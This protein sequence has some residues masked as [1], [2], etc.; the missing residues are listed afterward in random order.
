MLAARDKL[1]GVSDYLRE[2]CGVFGAGVDEAKDALFLRSDITAALQT[3]GPIDP[4]KVVQLRNAGDELRRRFADLA[5]VRTAMTMSTHQETLVSA[6]YSRTRYRLSTPYSRS[7]S[8]RLAHLPSSVP[9]SWRSDRCSISTSRRSD[10][11]SYCQASTSLDR[12]TDRQPALGSKMLN[13]ARMPCSLGGSPPSPTASVRRRWLSR[14]ATWPTRSQSQIETFAASRALPEQI[15]QA[16][17]NGLNQVFN[18]VDIRQVSPSELTSALFPD[19]APATANQLSDRLETLLKPR[20]APPTQTVCGSCPW[21]RHRDRSHQP[22]ELG[23]RCRTGP[24]R[25]SAR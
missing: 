19:T 2:A 1:A 11:R 6:N 10:A 3:E 4:A 7:R 20:S 12:S 14:S 17:I 5:S 23:Y 25:Q 15:G 13:V 18:R 24:T 9:T 21:K 22:V 8:L 16:F